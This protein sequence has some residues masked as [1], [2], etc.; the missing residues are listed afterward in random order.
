LTKM[1]EDELKI[2]WRETAATSF[3]RLDVYRIQTDAAGNWINGKLLQDNLPNAGQLMQDHVDDWLEGY[4]R[5]ALIS[6]DLVDGRQVIGLSPRVTVGNP[7]EDVLVGGAGSEIEVGGNGESIATSGFEVASSETTNG[8]MTEAEWLRS[9]GIEAAEQGVV[10]VSDATIERG[11]DLTVSWRFRELYGDQLTRL[12]VTLINLENGESI[13][14]WSGLHWQDRLTLETGNLPLEQGGQYR[15]LVVA[16]L[17]DGKVRAGYAEFRLG[18]ELAALLPITA[19]NI[20]GEGNKAIIDYIIDNAESFNL[21]LTNG[22]WQGDIHGTGLKQCKPW[23][24]E[25]IRDSTGVWL[26]Q[27]NE[28]DSSRWIEVDKQRNDTLEAA[29]VKML[30]RIGEGMNFEEAM[31]AYGVEAG[32]IVQM[33]G[34]FGLHTMVITKIDADGVWVLDTNYGSVDEG[35]KEASTGIDATHM[36]DPSDPNSYIN[37]Q[38][39]EERGIAFSGTHYYQ[40]DNTIR[41]HKMNYADTLNTKVS[42]A[43]IYRVTSD[44]NG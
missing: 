34:T 26:P 9:L 6:N 5:I 39:A 37:Q 23:L 15:T 40:E 38:Q 29:G 35:F 13:Q 42:A 20:E 30:G 11:N 24:Q 25:V 43:T 3:D 4:Y 19:D 27:N 14:T 32:D 41:I 36:V 2:S 16:H 22:I 18:S 28:E 21:Q 1:N 10:S 44:R 12:Q 8:P 31:E 7:E 33:T 17:S